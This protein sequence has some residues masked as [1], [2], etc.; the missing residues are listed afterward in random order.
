[1]QQWLTAIAGSL[2]SGLIRQWTGGEPE[3]GALFLLLALPRLWDAIQGKQRRI[4]AVDGACCLAIV[5]IAA[6]PLWILVLAAGIVGLG[7]RRSILGIVSLSWVTLA[8]LSAYPNAIL[9]V[10]PVFLVTLPVGL[11]LLVGFLFALLASIGRLF[12][13][14]WSDG[15]CF[16]LIFALGINFCLP[17]PPQLPYL[18]YEMAARKTLALVSQFPRK[19]WL[20]VGPIEQLAE[21]YGAAWYEDLGLFVEKYRDKVKQPYFKF[22]FSSQ[23]LLIFVEKRPFI[24]FANQSLNLPYSVLSDPTYRSY[25]STAGRASLQ[26]E[27]LQLCEDYRR[28]HPD[29]SSI[30]YEDDDLRIYYFRVPI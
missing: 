18:E 17:L 20:L 16:L 7:G 14:Q 12:L 8:L 6:F 24:T 2:N 27:A 15:I 13:K 22:P 9:S 23:H 10:D 19:S 1:V 25:R 29:S 3:I 4:A 26:F 28:H 5:A 21:S 11:S 30:Y